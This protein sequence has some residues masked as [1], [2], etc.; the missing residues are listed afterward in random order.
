MKLKSI[1]LGIFCLSALISCKIDKRYKLTPLPAQYAEKKG[2]GKV[3]I[4]IKAIVPEDDT[5]QL[6]YAI[7]NT[8][9]FSQD[10]S[11]FTQIKGNNAAQDIVFQLPDEATPTA[12]RLDL[13]ENR[14]QDDITIEQLNV[15]Y[16]G[17]SLTIKGNDFMD[18]FRVNENI[19]G[20]AHSNVLQPVIVDDNYDPISFSEGK[21]NAELKTILVK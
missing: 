4:T 17:K 14:W 1:F 10:L 6:F 5:F 20:A 18:Y 12:L 2:T 15:T 19:K 13:G 11:L 9:N 3:V 16:Y 7:D 21:F 8:D